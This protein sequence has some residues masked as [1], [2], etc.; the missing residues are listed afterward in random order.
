MSSTVPFRSTSSWN[1]LAIVAFVL[2]ITGFNVIPII[3]SAIALGQ[4]RRSGERGR[5]LAIAAIW[6]SLLVVI[7]IVAVLVVVGI[8]AGASRATS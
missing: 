2:S 6:I 1:P 7:A 3:L 5:G 8:V 4:I